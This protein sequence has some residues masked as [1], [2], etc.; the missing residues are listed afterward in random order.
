MKSPMFLVTLFTLEL[1]SPSLTFGAGVFRITNRTYGLLSDPTLTTQID[2][3]F[4]NMETQVN[5]ELSQ[6][7]AGSYLA[8][9]ANATA[10]AS[11]GGTH[12]LA[13]R[14]RYF[15]LSVG[16]GVAADF[17]GKTISEVAKD[18]DSLNSV[19]G[20][21]GNMNFTIGAPGDLLHLPKIGDFQPE[22][23]KIYLGYS[24]L[25]LR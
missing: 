21:S 8:G 12:D 2:Q 22:N 5:S 13:T 10:L 19:K 18:S 24:P 7:D 23:F 25:H 1:L 16:G 6:F 14:F 3:L 17:G 11:T 4:D 9:T 20:V 15:Y